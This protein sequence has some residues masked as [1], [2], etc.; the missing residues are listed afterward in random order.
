MK[1]W[2]KNSSVEMKTDEVRIGTI[3]A[4]GTV[5][6]ILSGTQ[7]LVTGAKCPSLISFP[8]TVS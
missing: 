1:N 8:S 4:V 3:I 6:A 2:T 5:L 7:V